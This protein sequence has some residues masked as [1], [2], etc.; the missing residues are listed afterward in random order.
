MNDRFIYQIYTDTGGDY[1]RAVVTDGDVIVEARLSAGYTAHIQTDTVTVR[2]SAEAEKA[3][4]AIRD[5][6]EFVSGNLAGEDQTY[7]V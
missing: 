1:D 7:V 5:V 3:E 2:D 4:N 6:R